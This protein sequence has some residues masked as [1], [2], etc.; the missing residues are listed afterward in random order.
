MGLSV[1]ALC[2]TLSNVPLQYLEAEQRGVTRFDV[3]K[4][5]LS[6]PAA[7]SDTFV[8][9]ASTP[10]G[11]RSKPISPLREPLFEVT[12]NPA[13]FQDALVYHMRRFGDTYWQ[14]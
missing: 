3:V 10:R 2:A 12:K 11:S 4:S 9:S 14:L 5:D 8:R 7:T 13:G 6:T 1:L